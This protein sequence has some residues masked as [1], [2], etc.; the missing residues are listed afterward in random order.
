MFSFDGLLLSFLTLKL[1]DMILYYYL[2]LT[3]WDCLFLTKLVNDVVYFKL[4]MSSEKKL[5]CT[6]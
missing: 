1:T 5:F 2:F 4:Q 3:V 6:H